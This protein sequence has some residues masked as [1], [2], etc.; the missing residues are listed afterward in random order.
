MIKI[1]IWYFLFSLIYA[2]KSFWYNTYDK[3][4]TFVWLILYLYKI[5]HTK[6]NR[7]KF[8]DF[9]MFVAS[10]VCRFRCLS[11]W[12]LSLPTFVLSDVCPF[13]RVVLTFVVSDVCRSDVCRCTDKVLVMFKE[14]LS[15]E[16]KEVHKTHTGSILSL[17]HT[18]NTFVC[19]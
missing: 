18:Q 4:L 16:L 12:R 2:E 9:L 11:F 5:N 15:T 10:D 1:T 13:W 6:V 14:L 19:T 8:C 7:I 17:T 3:L